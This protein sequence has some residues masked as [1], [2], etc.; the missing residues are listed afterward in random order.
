MALKKSFG[1]L[2]YAVWMTEF[3]NKSMEKSGWLQK[4]S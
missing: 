4:F 3:K 2:S 1:A